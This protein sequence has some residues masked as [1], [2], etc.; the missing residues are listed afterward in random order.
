MLISAVFYCTI[1][2]PAS[3]FIYTRHDIHT[4]CAGVANPASVTPC[5]TKASDVITYASIEAFPTFSVAHPTIP[6]RGTTCLKM[7]SYGSLTLCSGQRYTFGSIVI[8]HSMFQLSIY[9]RNW[10]STVCTCTLSALLDATWNIF[11]IFPENSS[12]YA[13]NNW[14]VKVDI[15]AWST[16]SRNCIYSPSVTKFKESRHDNIFCLACE[17]WGTTLPSKYVVIQL[18]L[19]KAHSMNTSVFLHWQC[20][21]MW[22]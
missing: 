3:S 6:S 21:V 18:I 11:T 16:A 1:C 15:R 4:S 9:I 14:C 7:N 20:I 19:H 10:S 8:P 22:Q 17:M 2:K 5:S 13:P 12:A